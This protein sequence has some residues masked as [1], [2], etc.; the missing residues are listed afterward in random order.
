MSQTL[1]AGDPQLPL[2]VDTTLELLG[3]SVPGARAAAEAARESYHEFARTFGKP[4]DNVIA[5]LRQVVERLPAYTVAERA[6]A[7]LVS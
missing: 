4:P 3:A 2:T 7:E 5:A 1:E 6:P